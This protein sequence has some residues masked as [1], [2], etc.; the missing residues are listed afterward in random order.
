MSATICAHAIVGVNSKVAIKRTNDSSTVTRYN[1]ETGEP[2]EK[3]VKGETRIF[4][5]NTEIE[6]LADI[7]YDLGFD[8]GSTGNNVSI[9]GKIIWESGFDF[10]DSRLC[11]VDMDAIADAIEDVKKLLSEFGI[12]HD[13]TLYFVCYLGC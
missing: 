12:D 1:E 9:I 13:P 3:T 4:F 5:G 6:S 11:K 7:E 10:E 8:I 2:Y